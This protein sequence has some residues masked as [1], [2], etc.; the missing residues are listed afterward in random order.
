MKLNVDLNH[1][2][3]SEFFSTASYLLGRWAAEALVITV[4]PCRMRKDSDRR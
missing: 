1:V 4:S 3:A 2:G